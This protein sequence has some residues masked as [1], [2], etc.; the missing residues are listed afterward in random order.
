M[1]LLE[2]ENETRQISTAEFAEMV[3]ISKA[4]VEKLKKNPVFEINP[5]KTKP[6]KLNGGL[7]APAGKGSK[8]YFFHEI[9]GIMH[10]IRF[11]KSRVP[12]KINPRITTYDPKRVAFEDQLSIYPDLDHALFMYAL[13]ICADSPTAQLDWHFRFQNKEKQAIEIRDNAAKISK[14]LALV[15]N[16]VN[17]GGL[18]DGEIMIV[19]KGI[20]AQNTGVKVIPNPSQKHKTVMEVRADLTQLIFKDVDVFL[21]STDSDVNEFY[22]MVLDAVDRGIFG[23]R[24]SLNSSVKSWYWE[25]GA[26]R[27]KLIVDIQNG[28]N[29]F[30]ALKG[31]IEADPNKYYQFVLKTVKEAAGRENV[32]AAIKQNKAQ[33]AKA[34]QAEAQ[35]E[36]KKPL[37]AK[38]IEAK[39]QQQAVPEE[40]EF[41]T[42]DDEENENGEADEI[43][44]PNDIEQE[45]EGGEPD[46]F[47]KAES[48]V[49]PKNFNEAAK[50]L[51]SFNNGKFPNQQL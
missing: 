44:G 4:V 49:I 30:D 16:P 7:I 42:Y 17:T 11:Y 26:L 10:I 19:A 3:G 33:A 18:S 12:D 36:Q 24:Q 41:E 51:Q 50:L 20:Y 8:P 5:T 13:P 25:V 27:N 14:A 37:T 31:A 48:Y 9:D 15:N 46:I 28:Q 29:D 21:D 6:D 47:K 40:E 2:S 23:I 34:V 35:P 1:L 22:G 38:D 45:A 32:A 43:L 39:H